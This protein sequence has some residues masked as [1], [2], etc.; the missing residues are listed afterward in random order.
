[1]SQI[2]KVKGLYL[3]IYG[4]ADLQSFPTRHT[5][6]EA[7]ADALGRVE[8]SVLHYPCCLEDHKDDGKHYH[9]CIKLSLSTQWGAPRQYLHVTYGIHVNIQQI[10]SGDFY[11]YRY[12]YVCKT[13]TN[14]Y[15][16]SGY[17]LFEKLG[18]HAQKNASV[19]LNQ[20]AIEQEPCQLVNP[21]L[22]QSAT[23]FT[24]ENTIHGRTWRVRKQ[25]RIRKQTLLDGGMFAVKRS[26][27]ME[28]QLFAA[29]N[30]G[31]LEFNND[32]TDFLTDICRWLTYIIHSACKLGKSSSQLSD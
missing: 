18:P 5:F 19:L 2:N 13:D 14:V 12:W 10:E 3:S 23:P 31:R 4:E 6:V 27:K 16:S 28:S 15:H 22:R 20:K 7:C 17:P 11:Y 32:L 29:A 1:M 8:C 26:I 21:L 9:C 30:A 25:R 24:A